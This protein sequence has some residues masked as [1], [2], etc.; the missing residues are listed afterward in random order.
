METKK[1]TKQF[2]KRVAQMKEIE[3]ETIEKQADILY[4][5]VV[6]EVSP[7][8]KKHIALTQK[9]ESMKRQIEEK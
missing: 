7:Y 5:K 6:Q 3:N 9:I 8:K 1:L 4:E 2:M